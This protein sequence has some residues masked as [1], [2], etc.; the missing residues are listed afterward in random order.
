MKIV[1]TQTRKKI[2]IPTTKVVIARPL[3]LSS[4][5]G[6]NPAGGA[7]GG[8]GDVVSTIIIPPISN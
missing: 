4:I 8:G 5:S 2:I 7:G 3:G 1:T 6:L